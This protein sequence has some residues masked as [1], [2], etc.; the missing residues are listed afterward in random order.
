[1]KRAVIYIRVSTGRQGDQFSPETQKQDTTRKADQLGFEVVKTFSDEE[2]GRTDNRE[3]LQSML[4][5]CCQKKNRIDAVIVYNFSRLNRNTKDFL[6]VKFLLSSHGVMLYSCM[7]PSGSDTPTEVAIQTILGA[8][9]QLDSENKSLIVASNMKQRFMQGYP[10]TKPSIGYKSTIIDER[11]SHIPN[12]PIF[13]VL[14]TMWY[15][16]RDEK[17]SINQIVE[18]LNKTGVAKFNKQTVSR[19]FSS[20][21]YLGINVSKKY[22]EVPAKHPAMI[23]YETYSQVRYILSGRRVS[24]GKRHHL[25]EDFPL[26]GIMLCPICKRFLSSAWS[27]G[28]NGKYGY[29]SCTNRTHATF[30]YPKEQ[31]EEEF[32][33]LVR[34]LNASEGHMKVLQELLRE[35]YDARYGML[36]QSIEKVKKDLEVLKQARHKLQIKH[37]QGMY[38]DEDYQSLNSELEAEVITK[39]GII[40]ESS[41]EKIDI[42]TVLAFINYYMQNLDKLWL[43]ATPDGK[44]KLA[45]SMFPEKLTFE[46][47]K[48]QTATLGLAYRLN[49]PEI[50]KS[51]LGEPYFKDI[52]PILQHYA[53]IYTDLKSYIFA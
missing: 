42:E 1:M 33:T 47:G 25:R 3:Q 10:L 18:E 6:N 20:K 23:D 24:E 22:G 28:R 7:E 5:F 44:L 16:I 21:Y 51:T 36:N 30:S 2:S 34:S 46:K 37:L 4:A 9:N 31:M 14:K 40:S 32:L 48:N 13:T 35:K 52:E 53:Q 50:L 29:Y 45:G 15:R 43:R 11:K 38:S 8:V 26:R 39:E 41:L 12:E 17:L 49:S 19:I 27:K